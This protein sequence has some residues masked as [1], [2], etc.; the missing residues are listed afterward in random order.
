MLD[1]LAN[2]V[3]EAHPLLA[4]VLLLPSLIGR[5]QSHR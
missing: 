1:S 5:L 2:A 3:A 4:R